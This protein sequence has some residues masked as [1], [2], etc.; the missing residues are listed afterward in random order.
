MPIIAALISRGNVVLAEYA[1]P[2]TNFP[3]IARRLAAQIP[4]SPDSKNS[5]NY[6]GHNFNYLV[7]GG[8]TYICMTDQDMKLR[9]PYAFLFDI[10]SKFKAAYK[11]RIATAASMAMNDT[12]SR[13]L[14]DRIDFFSNDRN[15]DQITKV[16]GEIEDAKAIMVKNIDKV[17]ERGERIEMLVSKTEDLHQ[18]SQSFKKKSTQLKR[19]MWWQNAR[20]CIVLIVIVIIILG[21][22][23]AVVCWK[24]GLFT[25]MKHSHEAGSSTAVATTAAE[26][27]S[28][29]TTTHPMTTQPLTTS[30]LTTG[31]A[32][33]MSWAGQ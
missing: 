17:L 11:E 30:Q 33:R 8:I 24:L 27:T 1:P 4:S 22:I 29:P 16:K 6:E 19:K 7:E 14:R 26:I 12:F 9:V 5:Y 21:A 13:V 28:Q 25:N 23:A 32:K 31:A 20:L 15:A 10:N 3:S 2:G 18:Q